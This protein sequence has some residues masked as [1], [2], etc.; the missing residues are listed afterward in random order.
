MASALIRLA[1]ERAIATV[2]IGHVTKDGSVAG[3]RLLEHL[4]DVVLHLRG[5][6]AQPRCGSVRAIKNRYGPT[7]EVGCFD[8]ERRRG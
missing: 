5:R 6:A 7:D 3:P 8:A 4:V 1:K 2:L